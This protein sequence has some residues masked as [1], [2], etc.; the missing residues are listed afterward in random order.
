MILTLA[1]SAM[2]LSSCQN[3]DDTFVSKSLG[4]VASSSSSG[5]HVRTVKPAGTNDRSASPVPPTGIVV[6][7]DRIVIDTKQARNFF[8]SLAK[9]FDKNIKKIE[10]DLQQNRLQTQNP[11]GIVITKDRIEVD[12]NKTERFME[13]WIKSMEKI[14]RELD[15]AFEQLDRSLQP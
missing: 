6:S 12:L 15:G 9:K 13:Q 10:A 7:E 5:G 14:G 2:L 11:T 1:I 4:E 8:E 3:Q